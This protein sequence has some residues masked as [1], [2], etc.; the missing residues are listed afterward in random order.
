MNDQSTKQKYEIIYF[1]KPKLLPIDTF[2]PFFCHGKKLGMF[3]RASVFVFKPDFKKLF[4]DTSSFN[5]EMLSKLEIDVFDFSF[6]K[7]KLINSQFLQKIIFLLHIMAVLI[8]PSKHQKVVFGLSGVSGVSAKIIRFIIKINGFL[9]VE[10]L[11]SPYT[12]TL[13]QKALRSNGKRE[14]N[15]A[16][17]V[18]LILSTNKIL[19]KVPESKKIII[20]HAGYGRASTHWW[21]EVSHF[22]RDNNRLKLPVEPF[23]YWPLCVLH[24]NNNGLD[25]HI[26]DGILDLLSGI[27]KLPNQPLIVFR[28]HPTT[29]RIQFAEIIKK[30]G[31]RNF[32]ISDVHSNV[33]VEKCKLVTHTVGSTVFSDANYRSKPCMLFRSHETLKGKADGV[34]NEFVFEDMAQFVVVDDLDRARELVQSSYN[35][36]LNALEKPF[37]DFKHDTIT[38]KQFLCLFDR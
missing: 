38:D 10:F 3:K 24:R 13:L 33:L 29:D 20:R 5:R 4:I 7:N 15:V 9:N 8:R 27:A 36:L 34:F 6:G 28:Y 21:N 32:I 2:M 23:I 12:E 26:G 19:D 16:D 30:S 1:M 31:Y 22:A 18:D 25:I 37:F 35:E 17:N 11:V 14:I